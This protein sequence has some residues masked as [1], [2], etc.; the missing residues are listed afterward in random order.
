MK[1]NVDF[2]TKE[3]KPQEEYEIVLNF[4]ENDADGYEQVH[5]KFGKEKLEDEAFMIEL[6]EFLVCTNECLRKDARGRGGFMSEQE[7]IREYNHI[8][9][10]FK[11]CSEAFCYI[12]DEDL[13]EEYEWTQLQVENRNNLTL[14]FSYMVPYYGEGWYDSYEDMNI[15]YYD[16]NGDRFPV[17]IDYETETA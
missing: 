15:Y 11:F 14:F 12:E 3:V 1:L 10:W 13:I 6:E 17:E 5:F 7:L 8:P 9:N 2:S 16:K 4:M